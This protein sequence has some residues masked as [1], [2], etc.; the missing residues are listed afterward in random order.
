LLA[1]FFM[2]LFGVG[3]GLKYID[4]D[5]N[6]DGR[7]TNTGGPLFQIFQR[8]IGA[9]F[10]DPGY[11][12]SGSIGNSSYVAAHL[13]FVI[14]FSAH[15]LFSGGGSF[16]N[17]RKLLIAGSILFFGVFFFLAATRGAFIGLGASVMAGLFYLIYTK[18]ALR[19]KLLLII[20]ALTLITGTGFYFRDNP[21]VKKIPA[22][23]IFDISFSTETFR[24]RTIVWSMA[25]NGFK[26]RPIFG[27]GQENFPEVFLQALRATIL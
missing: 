8:F 13:L 10:S 19:K 15:L 12:F 25:W 24:D 22:S 21:V 16:K 2:I 18:K 27:W 11:R 9:S 1:A 3:A 4:A 6:D 26:D 20:L 5:L 7:I 14:Y 17:K 23:R